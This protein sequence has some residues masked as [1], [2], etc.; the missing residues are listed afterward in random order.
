MKKLSTV[1]AAILL[2]AFTMT[3]VFAGNAAIGVTVS[4]LNVE[5]VG[6]E[7][8]RLTAAGTD[9]TDTSVRK[10]TVDDDTTTASIF[11]EYTTETSWPIT[12][13][14]EYTPG[15]ANISDKV[16]RTDTMTSITGTVTAVSKSAKRTAEADA[17]NFSTAYVEVPLYGALYVRAGVSNIDIDYVTTTTGVEKH[18]KY[19]DNINMTGTNLGIGLK[20]VTDGNMLWKLTYE[21]TDFD[22]FNMRTTGNS[23]AANSSAIS[24][25]V[26][27]AAI[28]LS[29][30]KQF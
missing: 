1:F 25:D 15:T 29:L 20:G 28:R 3:S 4:M 24:G 17:T 16:S 18:G 2:S 19:T 6:T 5:A 13:G 10:K 21:Q 8:D 11:A 12:L 26:D 27:T 9:V 14:F 7:T 23:V 30:G 22:G